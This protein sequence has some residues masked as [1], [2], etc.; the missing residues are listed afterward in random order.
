ML[1]SSEDDDDDDDEEEES[2]DDEDIAFKFFDTNAAVTDGVFGF[3]EL[4]ESLSLE[5]DD[6]SLDSEEL[7]GG[8]ERIFLGTL[9]IGI[10]ITS[11]SESDDD[12]EEDDD[13]DEES[14]EELFALC[15]VLRGTALGF[16]STIAGLDT[17][18]SDDDELDDEEEESEEEA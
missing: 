14:S 8:R 3:G 12:E 18:S 17:S 1:S 16:F 5:E 7:A 4:S 13:E 11:S 2:S 9:F 15:F 10:G 6:E